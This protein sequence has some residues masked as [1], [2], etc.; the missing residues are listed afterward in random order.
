[1]KQHRPSISRSEIA[2]FVLIP[3]MLYAAWTPF[4][5]SPPN[6][7][8]WLLDSPGLAF[9]HGSI[10]YSKTPLQWEND[11]SGRAISIELWIEPGEKPTNRLE[12]ILSIYDGQA[13]APLVVAQWRSALVL[14]SRRTANSGSPD[15]WE[16]GVKEA[17]QAG[18]RRLLTITS[19]SAQG[20]AIFLDGA[21]LTQHWKRTIIPLESKFGGR[22]L[23]GCSQRGD[24]AYR[25]AIFGVAIYDRTLSP[26]EVA[27]HFRS[28]H[29]RGMR[30]LGTTAGL[31]TLYPLDEGQGSEA[32]NIASLEHLLQIPSA[33]IPLQKDVLGLPSP[34]DR[35]RSWYMVDLLKNVAGFVPLGFF[36]AI[37]LQR[38]FR[39]LPNLLL[40]A[41]TIAGGLISLLIE[42]VQVQLPARHSSVSDLLYNVVGVLLG[43]LIARAF[44]ALEARSLETGLDTKLR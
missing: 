38:R 4:Q 31:L 33:F 3:C 39:L 20:T 35:M 29:T 34:R 41:M 7:V 24:G 2:L 44:L 25:G 30:A 16:L 17:L 43:A 32:F 40:F 21:P 13:T 19:S 42:L 5:I 10:V 28:L 8:E 14:R 27:E 18:E 1:M 12:H 36:G 22:L 9:R 23:L 15:Y 26:E 37:M 11:E 6:R